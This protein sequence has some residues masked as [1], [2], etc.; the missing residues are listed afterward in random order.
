[1][2]KP[3]KFVNRTFL[4]TLRFAVASPLY[5]KTTL[6]KKCPL[7]KRY[8]RGSTINKTRHVFDLRH[9]VERLSALK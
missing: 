8:E 7:Q 6:H 2:K 9:V 3:N 4:A 5:R 1:M